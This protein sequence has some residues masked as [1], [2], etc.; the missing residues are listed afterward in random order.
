M[1]GD[2]SNK[3]SRK[4]MQQE[5]K[6]RT[7]TGGVYLFQDAISGKALLQSTGSIEKAKSLLEFSK[8]TGSCV[9][10]SLAKE[11]TAHGAEAF[12]LE[13]LETIDKKDTQTNEEFKEDIIAL[14]ELWREKIGT[15]KLY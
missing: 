12:S 15:D 11:W 5:Y 10:P 9:H 7:V 6:E 13:I 1:S 4:E 3:K 2:T 14:E 8:A